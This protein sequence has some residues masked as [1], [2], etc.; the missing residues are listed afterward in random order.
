MDAAPFPS[1]PPLPSLGGLTATPQHSSGNLYRLELSPASTSGMPAPPTGKPAARPPKP[2]EV[3]AAWPRCAQLAGAFLL[4]GL[5]VLLGVHA[6][7]YLRQGAEPSK[8]EAAPPI[9]YRVDLNAARCAELMQLPGIGPNLADRI[10]QNRRTSGGFQSVD[11]LLKVQGIG[12]TTLDACGRSSASSR[13]RTDRS[14]SPRQ[15]P[16]K[17]PRVPAINRLPSRNRLTS[18]M[19]P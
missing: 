1:W 7:T 6:L 17:Q 18:T 10:E 14:K 13:R 5:T 12:P 9:A 19:P 3:V 8:I 11:D 2:P 15:A 4:G 16:R